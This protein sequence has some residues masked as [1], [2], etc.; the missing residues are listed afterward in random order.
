MP[1]MSMSKRTAYGHMVRRSESLGPSPRAWGL[2]GVVGGEGGSGGAESYRA[3]AAWLVWDVVGES[4]EVVAG[5]VG[6]V[7]GG[8]LF[9]FG[10]S[11][12]TTGEAGRSTKGLAVAPALAV[13]CRA[14]VPSDDKDGSSGSLNSCL[15]DDTRGLIA[16]RLLPNWVAPDTLLPPG[17]GLSEITC[18]RGPKGSVFTPLLRSQ[19][20]VYIYPYQYRVL[21]SSVNV[22]ML[23][24]GWRGFIPER[25]RLSSR[26]VCGSDCRPEQQR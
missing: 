26:G 24:I 15:S 21:N 2:K 19:I 23:V 8:T 22:V 11:D 1:S 13:L 12:G 3:E 17:K 16:N 4:G 7:D 14:V 18:F 10:R 25:T 20:R 6:G 9:C 5:L